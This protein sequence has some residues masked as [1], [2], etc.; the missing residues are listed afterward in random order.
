MGEDGDLKGRR[1]GSC[2]EVRLEGIVGLW[3]KSF[4]APQATG[5]RHSA[6]PGRNIGRQGT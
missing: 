4:H 5:S 1:R 3:G 2:V 6:T